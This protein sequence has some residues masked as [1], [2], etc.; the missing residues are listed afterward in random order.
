MPTLTLDDDELRALRD[1]LTDV[2]RRPTSIVTG[3]FAGFGLDRRVGQWLVAG[4]PVGRMPAAAHG[5]ALYLELRF[6][7]QPINP[8]PWL[9]IR[10]DKVS[11]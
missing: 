4:E 8:S 1:L 5:A 9:A 10:G 3:Q 11:G 6:H 7:G 2:T